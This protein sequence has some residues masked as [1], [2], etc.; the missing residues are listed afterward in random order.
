MSELYPYVPKNGILRSFFNKSN[1]YYND[2]MISFFSSKINDKRHPSHIFNFNFS[3]QN[4]WWS[5]GDPPFVSFCLKKGSAYLTKYEIMNSPFDSSPKIWSFSASNTHNSWKK[6][7]ITNY[8]MEYNSSYQV[9]F[10]YGPFRCF[11]LESIEGRNGKKPIDIKMLEIFG[12]YFPNGIKEKTCLQQMRRNSLTMF[13][14]VCM[15]K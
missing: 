15:F 14:I 10:N 6:V 8:T 13:I 5:S 4:Y 9:D 7:K 2:E 12:T 11:K 1:T 3:D